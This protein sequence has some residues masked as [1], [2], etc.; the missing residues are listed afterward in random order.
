MEKIS[1]VI[2]KPAGVSDVA[3]RDQ[4]VGDTAKRILDT[5]GVHGLSIL[6]PDETTEALAP[7]RITQVDDPHCGMVNVW[8]D[9]ADALDRA[10]IELAVRDVTARLV[11][12]LMVES[13]PLL[14]TTH[15]AAVG[16]RTPGTTLMTSITPKEGMAYD[17]FLEHWQVIQREVAME[18]QCTYRYVRN[19]VVRPLTKG[20]PPWAGIVE[21]GFPTEAVTDPMLWYKANG[22]QEKLEENRGRMIESVSAFLDLS[23]IE[24]HPTSEYVLKTL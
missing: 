5:P 10:P 16:A 14:N 20:A 15:T 9:L 8:V 23:K 13:V 22:S 19:V 12:Y 7:A 18:T 6:C 1:Y 11:G 21:E 2:W 24:S 3:F 4:L 17:A